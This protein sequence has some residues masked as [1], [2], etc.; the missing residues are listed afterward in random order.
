M[1]DA[2]IAAF[3]TIVA[4]IIAAVAAVFIAVVEFRATRSR[5]RAED[6]A[7]IRTEESRLGMELASATCKL[8]CVTAKAVFNR[9][10]NG[11]VEE[12]FEAAKDAQTRYDGYCRELAAKQACK[13]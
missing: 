4:A 11:D 9:E 6:R 13:V 3:A 5:K 10:T 8:A 7:A 1:G 2:W 12:A